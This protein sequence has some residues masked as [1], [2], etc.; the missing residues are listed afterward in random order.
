M[1][2]LAISAGLIMAIL[3]ALAVLPAIAIFEQSFRLLM[4]RNFVFTTEIASR[5]SLVIATLFVLLAINK[6]CEAVLTGQIMMLERNGGSSHLVYW[7]DGHFEFIWALIG[8]L[9]FLLGSWAFI[10]KAIF[11]YADGSLFP[12]AKVPPAP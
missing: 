5:V 3:G 8:W 9:L 6:T 10:R 1:L 2:T 12:S 11:K 7:K 4:G